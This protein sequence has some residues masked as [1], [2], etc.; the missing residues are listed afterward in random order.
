LE[1]V[2]NITDL[3]KALKKL[4]D[5]ELILIDTPGINP[6]NQDEIHEIK[7]Y[8]A[9]VADLQVHLVLCAT[10]KDKD[11][12]A[13]SEAF[14]EIGVHRLLF[15]KIDESATFGNI[16]NTLIR[17]NIPLS[18]LSSGRK[19]PKDIESGSIQRL[20]DLLFQSKDKNR[21]QSREASRLTKAKLI[22]GYG[23]TPQQ[24]HFVANR[25]SDVYHSPDCKWSKKIKPE[26]AIEFFSTHEAE[27]RNYL[28]CRSCNPDRFQRRNQANL[29]T[30]R[31]EVLN[32]RY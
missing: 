25:N 13:V 21:E 14:Q 31:R 4:K 28:P 5:K 30:E 12:I 6:G 2:V 32:Y 10:T 16:I 9:K 24:V 26:N 7:T 3:K 17:M 8:L 20:V 23:R 19:V 29:K 11:L 1:A 15:T 18:F 22:N 27:A